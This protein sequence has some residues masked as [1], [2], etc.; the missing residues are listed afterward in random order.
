MQKLVTVPTGTI[1]AITDAATNAGTVGEVVDIAEGVRRAAF[2]L[3]VAIPDTSSTS[4]P[5]TPQIVRSALHLFD[6]KSYQRDESAKQLYESIDALDLAIKN[7]KKENPGALSAPTNREPLV[8][9][10]TNVQSTVDVSG[11][12]GD[13]IFP[14]ATLL[15][16][17]ESELGESPP[18]TAT[19]AAD[20]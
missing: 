12:H 13:D 8:T 9:A 17:E 6:P 15:L 11:P 2:N 14:T 20:V 4:S 16:L 5:F 18:P 3:M 19:P 7:F 1:R 10:I